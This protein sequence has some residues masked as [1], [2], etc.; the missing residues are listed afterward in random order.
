MSLILDQSNDADV[1]YIPDVDL[2]EGYKKYFDIFKSFPSPDDDITIEQLSGLVYYMNIGS[3]P[4]ADFAIFGPHG[5]RLMCKLKMSG[6]RLQP[7][8]T[9]LS[10]EYKGPPSYWLWEQCYSILRTGLLFTDAAEL[11]P[12]E[13]Y[14]EKI[15]KSA[16][17]NPTAV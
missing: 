12:I 14:K 13:A 5:Q 6:L 2:K 3:P 10:V 17:E 15:K 9:F 16:M 7:D 4:W 8:G 1:P 11:E